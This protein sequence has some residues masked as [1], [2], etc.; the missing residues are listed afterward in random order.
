MKPLKPLEYYSKDGFKILVGR[1]STQ[2]DKLTTKIASKK[3][4]WFHVKDIH[5]A[6]V[7]LV[8]D[9]KKPSEEA[10]R[11]AANFS[12]LNSKACNSW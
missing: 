11:L 4:I 3:D 7:I 1:N 10:I 12:V 6:H 8:T 5:G 2:N 9:G